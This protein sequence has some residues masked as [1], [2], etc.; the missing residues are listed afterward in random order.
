MQ[1]MNTLYMSPNLT[2]HATEFDGKFNFAGFTQS[3]LAELNRACSVTF[4]TLQV[5][6]EETT[7]LHG[8]EPGWFDL[9]S[10]LV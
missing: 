2:E 6:T 4:G 7:V 5:V 9:G 10:G 8:F 3:W 1:Y